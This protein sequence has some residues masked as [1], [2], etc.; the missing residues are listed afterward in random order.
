MKSGQGQAKA[1]T[2]RQNAI[3]MGEASR[4]AT[5]VDLS[6]NPIQP[7]T[8]RHKSRSF[9]E[10]HARNSKC[11]L[12]F[13]PQNG[14]SLR[15]CIGAWR[16]LR[17]RPFPLT[18]SKNQRDCKICK[19]CK[20]WRSARINSHPRNLRMASFRKTTGSPQNH[21]SPL[22][23]TRTCRNRSLAQG[24]TPGKTRER[25]RDLGASAPVCQ[26]TEKAGAT[27]LCRL[28]LIALRESIH[29]FVLQNRSRRVQRTSSR[30]PP[31][32]LRPR[33]CLRLILSH[34]SPA[35]RCW[36]RIFRN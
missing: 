3:A 32:W 33:V 17:T 16:P 19:I 8:R 34:S 9:L 4:R 18:A 14:G 35:A 21:A 22:D 23:E 1:P 7:Q 26:K 24:D 12:G 6:Q 2:A 5:P 27:A 25:Q 10:P 20:I 36:S 29:G 15:I 31:H 11:L 28:H 13:V 30:P